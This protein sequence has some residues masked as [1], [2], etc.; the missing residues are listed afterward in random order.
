MA[1]IPTLQVEA[2][3]ELMKAMG[4]IGEAD[5]DLH[6]MTDDGANACLLQMAK[7]FQATVASIVAMKNSVIQETGTANVSFQRL[8]VALGEL[9]AKTND[10]VTKLQESPTSYREGKAFVTK[11][12]ETKSI[13]SS[14]V[15]G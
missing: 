12:C 9:S 1:T 2:V 7:M 4:D 14:K 15:F 10:M 5:L 13:A 6:T 8:E 11:V 3:P